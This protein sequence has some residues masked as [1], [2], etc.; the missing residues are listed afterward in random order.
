MAGAAFGDVGNSY[1]VVATCPELGAPLA[2]NLATDEYTVHISGMTSVA[3][4][5]LGTYDIITYA[6]LAI[7]AA[8][9]IMILSGPV[10]TALMPRMSRL[11]AEGKNEH[12]IQLYRHSTQLVSVVAAASSITV[13][14]CAEALLWA[15]TGNLD[16][17]RQAAP[18]LSS[19][20]K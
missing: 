1:T 12:L 2:F 17:A 3:K 7:V 10:G 16:F 8:S 20:K 15:W 6:G 9:G 5:A 4:L 19:S 11:E 14:V 13:A 18:N